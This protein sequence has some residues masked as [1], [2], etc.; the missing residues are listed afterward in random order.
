MLSK[1][2][3]VFTVY[4]D[5]PVDSWDVERLVF[6]LWDVVPLFL[7]SPETI[8]PETVQDYLTVMDTLMDDDLREYLA[9]DLLYYNLGK[10]YKA[11]LYINIETLHGV[12]RGLGHFHTQL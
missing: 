9:F 10:R 1:V 3:E 2:V 5:A 11:L 12:T 4:R 6:K 7:N 8:Y